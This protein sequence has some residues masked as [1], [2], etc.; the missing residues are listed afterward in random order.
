MDSLNPFSFELKEWVDSHDLENRQRDAV[1]IDVGPTSMSFRKLI[2]REDHN[3]RRSHE[4]I[5]V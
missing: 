5:N 2:E 1:V 3:K 4:P